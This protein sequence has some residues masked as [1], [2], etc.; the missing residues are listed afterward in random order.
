MPSAGPTATLREATKRCA[1]TSPSIRAAWMPH[2][3]AQNACEHNGATSTAAGSPPTCSAP[4]RDH[5]ER[6]AGDLSPSAL[7]LAWREKAD[8]RARA[9]FAAVVV[10]STAVSVVAL[11]GRGVQGLVAMPVDCAL[12]PVL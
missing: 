12:L 1:T 5:R 8:G 11:C 10:V 9:L 3:L 6:S 7:A 2:G 4:S